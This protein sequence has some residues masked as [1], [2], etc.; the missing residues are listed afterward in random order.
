MTTTKHSCIQMEKQLFWH[1]D[2]ESVWKDYCRLN[3]PFNEYKNLQ[4]FLKINLDEMGILGSTGVLQ[5]V[6]SAEVKK[7]EKNTQDNCNS[8]TIVWIGSAGGTSWPGYS[9]SN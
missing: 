9:S 7:H 1:N 2:I 8:I 5:I 3:E 6:G 4:R